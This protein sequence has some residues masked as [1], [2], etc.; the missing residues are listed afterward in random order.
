MQKLFMRCETLTITESQMF[1][2]GTQQ[3]LFTVASTIEL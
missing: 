2:S 3:V 1:T